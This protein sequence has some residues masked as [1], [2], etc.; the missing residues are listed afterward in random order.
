[1]S[2]PATFIF[3]LF[4]NALF[5]IYSPNVFATQGR[6]LFPLTLI[7]HSLITLNSAVQAQHL[8]LFPGFTMEPIYC[9]ATLFVK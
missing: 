1:M 8:A 5:L 4:A 7:N 2:H 6:L 3:L 9:R